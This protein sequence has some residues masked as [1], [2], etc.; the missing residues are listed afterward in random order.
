MNEMEDSHKAK[1]ETL[2]SINKLIKGML[3]KER[4]NIGVQVDEGELIWLPQHYLGVRAKEILWVARHREADRVSAGRGNKSGQS[5]SSRTQ[6]SRK[7]VCGEGRRE[8]NK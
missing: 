3:D 7:R 6:C 5:G 8:E 2:E 1:T 4:E